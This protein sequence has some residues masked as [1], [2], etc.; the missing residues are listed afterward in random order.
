[1]RQKRRDSQCPGHSPVLVAQ[2]SDVHG[3]GPPR[4][5]AHVKVRGSVKGQ[6]DRTLFAQADDEN[7]DLPQLLVLKNVLAPGRREEQPSH[8]REPGRVAPRL[9]RRQRRAL[10]AQ[11]VQVRRVRV[12]PL[13]RRLIEDERRPEGAPVV[14]L[15]ARKVATTTLGSWPDAALHGPKRR[16][17]ACALA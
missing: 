5:H 13:P 17:H 8:L 4:A 15:G 3:E 16:L 11:E 12:S 10:P 7:D 1:M 2:T 6:P 9:L 14:E